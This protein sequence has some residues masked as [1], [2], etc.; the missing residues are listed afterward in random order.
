MDPIRVGPDGQPDG[1]RPEQA[2]LGVMTAVQEIA[3]REVSIAAIIDL[4]AK[5]QLA[6]F[7]GV[8]IP[9]A[10][11]TYRDDLREL[12]DA[13]LRKMAGD[14]EDLHAT[15]D[16]DEDDEDAEDEPAKPAVRASTVTLIGKPPVKPTP[17][18]ARRA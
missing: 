4:F 17:A 6:E 8:L 7:I 14:G 11:Q 1:V 16:D 15:V 18:P 2:M 3:K 10:P 5:G 12:I 13:E 9:D